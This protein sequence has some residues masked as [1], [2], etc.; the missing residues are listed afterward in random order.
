M[1]PTC[2]A[3]FLLLLS[4][5]QAPALADGPRY[6][7]DRDV[8][9]KRLALELDVDF[10]KREV[11]GT[12]TL[13]LEAI[14]TPL[15]AL[16]LDAVD[17]D[18][19]R[20][21]VDGAPRDFAPTGE[22]LR[23]EGPF[24]EHHRVEVH[25]AARPRQQG[26]HWFAPT[27]DDPTVPLQLWSQGESTDARRWFPC[28]DDPQ[29]RQQT[30]LIVTVPEGMEAIS[31][32]ELVSR[33]AV[34]LRGAPRTRFH[35]RQK[36]EH[37]AYLVT[38]VVGEFDIVR[39]DWEGMPVLHYVPKGRAADAPR[40]FERTRR[41]LDFFSDRIGIRYPYEKYVHVVV[42]QFNHG[43]ME[44]TTATTLNERTLGDE[45]AFIDHSSDDLVAHEL[46][47]QWWGDLLTCREWAHI[48][49][50]EGFASYFEALW[51]EEKDGTDEFRYDLLQKSRGA[52]GG[53]WRGP[54]VDRRYA[55]PDDLFDSR[56]YPKGAWV[57]H[58]L[59]LDLGD[60][61]FW[62]GIRDYA[63][64]HR[65]SAVDT[66]DLRKAFERATGRSL[67][68]YFAQWTE[69]PGHPVV[70][71][72]FAWRDAEK[73]AEVTLKQRQDGEAF[74]FAFDVA[75]HLAAENGGD[76]AGSASRVVR[77]DVAEKEARL[78]VPLERRPAWIA[79]DARHQ[80]LKEATF[81]LDRD[82]L[83]AQLE[84]D[85][86]VVG[87]IEAARTL[88]G[89]R[90]DDAVRALA[91][92]LR[93]DPFWAV[94]AEVA[95]ALGG[96]ATDAAREALL[97]ALAAEKHAKARRQVVEALGRFPKDA[98]VATALV[99]LLADD[100]R[101]PSYYVQAEAARALARTH[102]PRAL[103]V[104]AGLL[105]RPSH[106]EVVRDAAI[107]GIGALLD[108]RG[109][110]LVA[111][112]AAAPPPVPEVRGAALRAV[113]R[114]AARK[115]AKDEQREQALAL[116]LPA[117]DSQR[118]SVRFSAVEGLREL[119]ASAEKALPVLE[120]LARKDPERW[121]REA[122]GRA[123]EKVR[124]GEPADQEIAR[125]RGELEKLA[126]EGRAL[127]E[128]LERVEARAG[129]APVEKKGGGASPY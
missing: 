19:A 73:L 67:E 3:A 105:R 96:L 69:R 89:T 63:R 118:G 29:E 65:E 30:Q 5:I 75:F 14:R 40:S 2:L 97:G 124:A 56:A 72:G 70:D 120:A 126:Q 125:L 127:R 61:L 81:H 39:E 68:G 41:M 84:R 32:G 77:L 119:G 115:E 128:R 62:R 20:V 22:K 50:N 78:L 15:A 99:D 92:A 9:V 25:Y 107:D 18:V 27:P 31:N 104:L 52:L 47:H 6:A 98:Q 43:G 49:L 13:D 36:V 1:R 35:W 109:I 86:H 110:A 74:R 100:A 21:L 44:N 34:A 24:L 45:R 58:M 87:R 116:L 66:A 114:L 76:G 82:L 53:G 8:D 60:D 51:T 90:A 12:A 113:A 121:I 48:W 57:L 103:D 59:R 33:E 7:P 85:P 108:P 106:N 122:S 101:E 38:L 17:L 83:I 95:D 129:G 117:L 64:T 37:T 88:A 93:E 54:I 16:V 123:V 46:A 112:L 71:V 79:V 55:D 23:I 80:V 4:G 10:E 28:I 111:P 94:R 11:R 102:D 91:K 26:L 42:E